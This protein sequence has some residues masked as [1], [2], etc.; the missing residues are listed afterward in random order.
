MTAVVLFT[1]AAVVALWAGGLLSGV[2][3]GRSARAE[4]ERSVAAL[5]AAEAASQARAQELDRPATETETLRSELRGFVAPL[6]ER[7]AEVHRLSEDLRSIAGAVAA[8]GEEQKA[9]K[10]ALDGIARPLA[11][12]TG[13]TQRLRGE[14]ERMLNEKLD[15]HNGDERLRRVVAEAIR[16]LQ[17]RT[18]ADRL[19]EVVSEAIRPMVEGELL[20]VDLARLRLGES[21]KDLNELLTAVATHAGLATVVLADER[22]LVL[23]ENDG[24][25]DAEARAGLSALTLTLSDS[26][27][28]S[29]APAPLAVMLHDAANQMIVSRIFTVDGDRFVLTAVSKGRFIPPNLLDPVLDK[30]EQLMADWTTAPVRPSEAIAVGH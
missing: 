8:S 5:T 17:E 13:E 24:A 21:R 28:Q 6:L 30:I 10:V 12:R 25:R 27:I 4:L 9:L 1:I 22:G 20:G 19:R 3:L 18:R 29:G 15:A 26:H 23:A 2:R 11:A 7:E 16:P 14:L